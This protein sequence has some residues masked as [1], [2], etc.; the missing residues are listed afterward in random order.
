[1]NS[2]PSRRSSNPV[3]IFRSKYYTESIIFKGGSSLSKAY[4][5]I[6][7]FSEDIDLIIDH[8]YLP[9]F[10]EPNSKSQIKKPRKASD[11]F[12]INEFRTV[13]SRLN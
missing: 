8:H 13:A 12:I 5:V 6:E 11:G 10:E 4:Q 9:G 1:M 3:S 2:W 7:S